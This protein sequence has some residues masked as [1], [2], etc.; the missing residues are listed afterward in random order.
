[1]SSSDSNKR[2]KAGFAACWIVVFVESM[3]CETAY[4]GPFTIIVS[5]VVK[6]AF[7]AAAVGS[8]LLIGRVLLV[9]SVRNMW[10]RTGY[11][12][13]LISGAGLAVIVFATELGIRTVEPVS[14]YRM[15]SSGAWFTCLV[16]IAFPIV[17][18]PANHE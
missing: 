9:P 7:A 17:N 8:A 13:L 14:N 1:M 5:L 2:F 10:R 3:F 16:A 18:L 4:G 12:S 11:W 15:M 6:T